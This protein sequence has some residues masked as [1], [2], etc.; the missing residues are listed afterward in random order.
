MGQAKCLCGRVRREA[1]EEVRWLLLL[2]RLC[3]SGPLLGSEVYMQ[4]EVV[5]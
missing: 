4:A 2:R 1:L 5:C 3:R